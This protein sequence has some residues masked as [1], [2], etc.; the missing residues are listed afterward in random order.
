MFL[1]HHLES[2]GVSNG[3][4]SERLEVDPCWLERS[5]HEDLCGLLP[6]FLE[7]AVALSG[8]DLLCL[9]AA[10]KFH[11]CLAGAGGLAATHAPSVA[12][13][14]DTFGHFT[15]HHGLACIKRYDEGSA[16][17][18]AISL[19][20]HWGQSTA[21]QLIHLFFA[22][23]RAS[24]ESVFGV[25]A[26][27]R[28][29]RFRG[30]APARADEINEALGGRAVFGAA[31]NALVMET[32]QLAVRAPSYQPL[33]YEQLRY[34]ACLS[35]EQPSGMTPIRQLVEQ[36]IFAGDQTIDEVSQTLEI[37][38]RTLQRR[39]QTEGVAFRS[40]LN[41][42]RVQR[43][44][45]LLVESDLSVAEIASRLGYGDDKALRKAVKAVT[46]HT[47]TE[48]RAKRGS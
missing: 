36:A 10:S 29:Y 24:L 28:E 27:P 3:K 48:I 43:A 42:A 22:G 25:A 41:E 46:G 30:E 4:L 44:S 17:S 31:R 40:V 13:A 33:L 20:D 12:M 32:S 9:H 7:A 11:F 5:T 23:S 16:T 34:L 47:P 39:L 18:F 1:M 6:G 37:N 15:P 19:L 35:S 2:S 14:I 38:K 45:A 21:T 8:D 26:S